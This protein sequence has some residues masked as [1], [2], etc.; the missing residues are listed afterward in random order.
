ME[1]SGKK[2]DVLDDLEC[3]KPY[4]Q[5]SS[6]YFLLCIEQRVLSGSRLRKTCEIS[7]W[8]RVVSCMA[9]GSEKRVKLVGGS[10]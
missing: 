3:G 9:Q 5:K 2:K 4:P 10:E 1:R 6:N 7:W 8:V